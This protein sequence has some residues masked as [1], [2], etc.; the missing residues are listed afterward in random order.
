M[1]PPS[2]F[3][4][5]AALREGEGDKPSIHKVMIAGDARRRRRVRIAS[6][7]VIVAV[8][9]GLG[10]TAAEFGGSNGSSGSSDAAAHGGA[11]SAGGAGLAV[12]SAEKDA[13][14]R[15]SCPSAAPKYAGAV[16]NGAGS[17]AHGSAPL[18]AERVSS[19]VVCA[20]GPAVHAVSS[21]LRGPAR[22]E[23]AGRQAK[24]VANS[25]ENAPT[26]APTATCSSS[27]VEQYAVI[28]VD[29]SG[30]TGQ[31]VAAQLSAAGCA[32]LVTNGTA[33]RYD[34]QPPPAVASKLD[35][36]TPTEPP[37]S[38]VPASPTSSPSPTS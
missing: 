8:A 9:G 4:L 30:N 26:A 28:P 23:L 6:A 36:L 38:P 10:A 22:L 19:V 24:R 7:A 31:P 25:L 14:A 13:L 33:I 37:D 21:Q 2:E 5:R 20:Y 12:P 3:D 15:V 17:L 34:W 1:A 32:A 27:S 29:S 16:I 11:L 18:F 35:E